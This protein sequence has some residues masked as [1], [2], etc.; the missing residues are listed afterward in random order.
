MKQLILKRETVCELGEE[1][2]EIPFRPLFPAQTLVRSCVN[3]RN[4]YRRLKRALFCSP[5]QT[6]QRAVFIVADQVNN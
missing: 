1:L 3:N 2:L 6:F 5:V 4:G